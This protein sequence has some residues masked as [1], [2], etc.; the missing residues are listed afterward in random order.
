ML[1][2]TWE[3]FGKTIRFDLT[4]KEVEIETR[5]FKRHINPDKSIGGFVENT[6]RVS[7]D[8]R[9]YGDAITQTVKTITVSKFTLSFTPNFIFG[10]CKFQ[11]KK[12]EIQKIKFDKVKEYVTKKEFIALKKICKL[13][14]EVN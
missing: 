10:G 1:K 7:G 5:V 11:W 6:A 9:V 8:A 13:M 3:E 12:S 14:L 4:I 2:S